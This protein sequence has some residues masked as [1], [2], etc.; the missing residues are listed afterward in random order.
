MLRPGTQCDRQ[1]FCFEKCG[2]SRLLS[3]EPENVGAVAV[4]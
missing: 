2:V 1:Y 3:L 4:M